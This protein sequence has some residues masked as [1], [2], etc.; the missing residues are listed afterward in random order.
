MQ[1]YA[2][3]GDLKIHLYKKLVIESILFADPVSPCGQVASLTLCTLYLP[4][5]STFSQC[6]DKCAQINNFF[7]RSAYIVLLRSGK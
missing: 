7:L 3:M 1:L 4:P 6:I 5:V 2:C